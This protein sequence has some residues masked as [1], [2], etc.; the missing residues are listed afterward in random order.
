[1]NRP[2]I[3]VH[4][5]TKSYRVPE[6]GAGLK[7]TLGSLV[8]RTYRQVEAV[9]DV[10][11]SIEAGEIVGFLGP[12]GAGKTTTLKLLAGL[13]HPTS[14]C[15]SVAGFVPWRREPAFLRRISMVLGNKS[16]MLWAIPP[17]DTFR[18]LGEIYGVPPAQ[19]RTTLDEL[20]TLLDLTALVTKP[21]RTLSLGERMKCEL[22]C[23]LLYRPSVLF[24]DEPTLGLDV[25]MQA[26]LRVFIADYNRRASATI[27]LTSHTLADIMA[28]CSRVLFIHDGRL[29]Y[30]GD[31]R[32]LARRLAPF[33]F[34]DLMLYG[35]D[36]AT[37]DD[38]VLPPGASVV[39]SSHGHL[40]VR[41]ERAAAPA[42]AAH[43]LQTLPVEDLTVEDPPIETIV[44]QLY[45]GGPR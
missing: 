42:I 6:R 27:L 33:K 22:V 28:L 3:S 1:M 10:T 41:A 40:R 38:A 5:L 21:V 25:T 17:L 20:I 24:L 43:L 7:A 11:F 44:D 16:Q 2:E 14:G 26:R 9:Q 45:R 32:T 39:A 8:Q 29:R 12:N 4:G 31:L 37:G 13:L 19:L 23:A 15:A 35:D 36:P 18:V 30:D 34:I